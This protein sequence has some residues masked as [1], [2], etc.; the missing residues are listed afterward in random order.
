MSCY[1]SHLDDIFL[2]AGIRL[3]GENRHRV[4][5]II[6]EIIGQEGCPQV[7]KAVKLR[8]LRS[9]TW[10]QFVSELRERWREPVTN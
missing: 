2:A 3:T 10:E 7:W 9:D 1:L 8:L 6:Q 4:H 5:E